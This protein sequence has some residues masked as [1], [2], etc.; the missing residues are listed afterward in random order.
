ML[1]LKGEQQIAKKRQRHHKHLKTLI[2]TMEAAK[3][4]S[5]NIYG[6]YYKASDVT[7]EP[8]SGDSPAA[9]EL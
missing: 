5:Q 9:R 7:A 2:F 4:G 1:L 6:Y 3:D 8:S